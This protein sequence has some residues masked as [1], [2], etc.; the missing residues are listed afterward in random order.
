MGWLL[1]V[2]RVLSVLCVVLFVLVASAW[3]HHRGS[4]IARSLLVSVLVLLRLVM[5]E[6]T[7]LTIPAMSFLG[8]VATW[9]SVREIAPRS[10]MTFALGEKVWAHL[11]K[12]LHFKLIF[13]ENKYLNL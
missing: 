9:C 3:L 4:V 7:V 2:R 10:V 12:R 11:V 6:V 13:V 1:I 8:K 5:A